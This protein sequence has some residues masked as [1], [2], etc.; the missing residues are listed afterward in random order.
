MDASNPNALTVEEFL[1]GTPS[2]RTD[3]YA[4]G[5]TLLSLRE[6]I[7]LIGSMGAKFTPELKGVDRD[8]QGNP[9]V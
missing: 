3:L 9:L 8:S 6:S 1:G 2:F 4:T 5:A 7:A